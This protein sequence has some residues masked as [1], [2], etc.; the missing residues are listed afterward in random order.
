MKKMLNIVKSLLL[1]L[2]AKSLGNCKLKPSIKMT[3]IFKTNMPNAN[4]DVEQLEP[5]YT[6]SGNVKWSGK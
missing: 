2:V 6:T 5:L 3:I 1:F 4:K